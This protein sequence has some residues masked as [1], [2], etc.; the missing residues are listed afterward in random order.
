MAFKDLD[1]HNR[2]V[3]VH[4]DM[5]RHAE[6]CILGGITQVGKVIVDGTV[7][8][9]AGTDGID[10]YY[11]PDFVAPMSR[12]QLRYLVAHEAAHRALHHCTD[13][14]S[15]KK[16]HPDEFAQAIDYV[17]NA[18]I[19]S[20]DTKQDFLERP[21]NV[22]PLVSD[23]YK[24]MSVPEVVRELLKNPRP[25]PPSFDMHMDPTAGEGGS[26]ELTEAQ[27]QA[28]AEVKQQIED[29][30]RQGEIMQNQLRQQAGT[31]AGNSALGGFRER[32]TDWRGPLRRFVSE[33]SEGDSQSRFS[34]PA[35]RFMPLGILLPSHFEESMDEL[36][37]ACDTS[38]SMGGIYPLVFGEIARIAQQVNPKRVRVLWWDTKIQGDVVYTAQ[39]Y[40]KLGKILKPMGGGGTTVSCVAQHIK[41]K[42]YKARATIMLTDGYVES[43]YDTPPGNLL[44][45]IVGNSAFRAARGKVLHIEED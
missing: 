36:I 7:V 31:Q 25:K 22:P 43:S 19:E 34:P 1:I 32:K 24:D 30:L 40:D 45:G 8:P 42:K 37:V 4:T 27:A 41:I 35:K 10:T 17:V 20:M 6:F 5:L 33:I 29:A 9:T 23:K 28:V 13:Y 15:L 18:A 3:A 26:T 14:V 12:K 38:G 39:D 11:N 21:T 2:L 44:W 16:K